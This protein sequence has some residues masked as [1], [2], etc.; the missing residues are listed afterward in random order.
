MAT[1]GC[2]DAGLMVTDDFD[3]LLQAVPASGAPQGQRLDQYVY[4]AV[5]L[6]Q[7]DLGIF[8]PAAGSSVG[9]ETSD[10]LE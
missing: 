10:L 6:V 9:L 1:P 2:G 4:G 8:F 7:R 3:S 5:D